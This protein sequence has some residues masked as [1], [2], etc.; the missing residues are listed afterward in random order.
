L[1]LAPPC[2]RLQG[3]AAAWLFALTAKG[4]LCALKGEPRE[5][6]GKVCDI[7]GFVRTG[8]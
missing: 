7:V 6:G 8:R 1:R 3:S 2:S 5:G 4:V